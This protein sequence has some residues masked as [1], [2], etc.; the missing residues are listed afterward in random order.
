MTP[1]LIHPWPNTYTFTKSLAEW[2]LHEEAKDLPCAIFRPSIIGASAEE[3][4]RVRRTLA[5]RISI[6]SNN[7]LM[8]CRDGWTISTLRPESSLG[9]VLG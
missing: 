1:K 3:P 9:F 4:I 6:L 8:H 2:L 7:C 5:I